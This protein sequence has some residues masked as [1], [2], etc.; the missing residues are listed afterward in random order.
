MLR[1]LN[2]SGYTFVE[3]AIA[4]GI[5][6]IMASSVMIA[7]TLMSKQTVDTG[8]KAYAAEKAIQMFEELK[9]LSG[10]R[11]TNLTFLDQFSDPVYVSG[12]GVSYY[13]PLLTTDSAVSQEGV[14]NMAKA[15]TDPVSGN[16][17]INGHNRYVRRI[18]VSRMTNDPYARQVDIKVWLYAADSAPLQGGL[19]LADVGGILRTLS[20]LYPPSQAIDFYVLAVQTIP[21]WW[22]QLADMYATFQ[23]IIGDI[24]SRTPG[25]VIRPHYITRSGYGRD[26]YYAPLINKALPSSASTALNYVYFYP[27]TSIATSSSS[28]ASQ[29]PFLTRLEYWNAAISWWM[30]R[31]IHPTPL[32]SPAAPPIRWRTVTITRCA[33]PT[34]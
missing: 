34:S 33:T 9:A 16:K 26:Q 31:L 14:T 4:M 15:E 23:G 27:G 12:S 28:A 29:P 22:A 10:G 11:E 13:N 1:R 24:Q 5:M 17:L 32:S 8:D 6:G 3:L 20:D 7:R 19:L 18:T 2:P 25:L 30:A 21:A